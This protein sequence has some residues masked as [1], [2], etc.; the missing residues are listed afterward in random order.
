MSIEQEIMKDLHG[1]VEGGDAK[2][3]DDAPVKRGV[4]RPKKDPNAVPTFK[5]GNDKLFWQEAFIA[6][7]R[8]FQTRN[9][10]DL[11]RCAKIADEAV[12]IMREYTE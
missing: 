7:C 10:S 6:A 2:Q 8:N 11:E 1:D 12:K 4:G 3:P 9:P 5:V